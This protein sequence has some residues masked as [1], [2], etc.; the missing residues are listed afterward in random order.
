MPHPLT[1]I[2]AQVNVGFYRLFGHRMRVQGAQQLLLSTV[3]AKSGKLRKTPLGWFPNGDNAWLVA[4]TAAGSARHPAW[5][6]NLARN[7]DK[8]WIEVGKRTL[9]VRPASLKGAGRVAAWQ[10]IVAQAPGYGAYQQKTD[11]EIP[12]V[13]LTLAE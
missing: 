8:V 7:P 12:I 4:A 11:R 13:R 2:F 1:R 5:Y 3:G 9:R 6:F 10:R